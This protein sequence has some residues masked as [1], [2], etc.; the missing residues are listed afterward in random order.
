M[1]EDFLKWA[2]NTLGIFRGAV[3]ALSLAS[4]LHG[5]SLWE[6]PEFLEFTHAIIVHWNFFLEALM[7][8]FHS[9]FPFIP[10]L[11]HNA[12]NLLVL[13][14]AWLP[15]FLVDIINPKTRPA[16]WHDMLLGVSIST[17]IVVPWMLNGTTYWLTP[18]ALLTIT[19]LFFVV[20]ALFVGMYFFSVN[21]N[22]EK[23][24]S[25]AIVGFLIAL[26]VFEILYLVPQ[27]ASIARGFVQRAEQLEAREESATEAPTP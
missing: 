1:F 22:F 24:Y 13:I 8:P 3:T 12:S 18:I 21:N 2:W 7:R 25:R 9:L 11:S 23:K 14:L 19:W 6:F 5:L 26:G 10:K 17:L 20:I 15:Y 4:I 27:V 16:R